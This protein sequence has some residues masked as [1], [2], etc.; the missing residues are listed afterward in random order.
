MSKRT[1]FLVGLTGG[2][3]SG[4]TVVGEQFVRL[5]VPIIDADQIARQ[6]TAKGMPITEKIIQTFGLVTPAGDLDRNALRQH[7]FQHPD[8]KQQLEQLLHPAIGDAIRQ[9]VRQLTSAVGYAVLIAPLLI[10]TGL[11]KM[12]SLIVVVDAEPELQIQRASQRDKVSAQQ[13]RQI[14]QAQM[15][16]EDR[17]SYADIIIRNDAQDLSRL[18]QQV[19]KAHQQILDQMHSAEQSGKSV[20]VAEPLPGK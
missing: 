19:A 3:A 6:L 13:V 14:M 18:Q 1:H 8:A 12:C 11:H 5:G 10:E 4:K 20:S 9:Q 16:A 7:I 15:A 2:I 17:L